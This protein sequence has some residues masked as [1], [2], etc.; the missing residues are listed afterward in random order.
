MER[1]GRR[2]FGLDQSNEASAPGGSWGGSQQVR[3]TGVSTAHHPMGLQP[4]GNAAGA[5]AG[6]LKAGHSA[7]LECISRSQNCRAQIYTLFDA[8]LPAVNW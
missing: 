8:F 1:R 7:V 3:L 5:A 2:R 4:L 6:Q